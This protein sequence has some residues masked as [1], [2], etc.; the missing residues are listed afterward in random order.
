ME[1]VFEH[2]KLSNTKQP[3]V[4]HDTKIDYKTESTVNWH[5]NIEIFLG[6]SGKGMVM[7]DADRFEIGEGDIFVVNSCS[8]HDIKTDGNLDFYCLIIDP[9]FCAEN[10]INVEDIVFERRI[11]DDVVR[12][13]FSNIVRE[14]KSDYEYKY[15]GIRSA[16]LSLVLHLARY[17]TEDKT[18]E[19]KRVSGKVLENMRIAI[20]YIKTHYTENITIDMVCKEAGLSKYHFAREFKR[21]IGVTPVNYINSLRIEKAKKMLLSGECSICEVQEKCGFDNASYFTALFRKVTG[22]TPTVFLKNKQ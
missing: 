17:H 9:D 15:A 21:I 6:K 1:Y 18:K 5:R 8:L 4:L 11:D 13:L 22:M 16:V 20:G 19:K 12:N 7:I 14:Y 3:I 10:D 2:F